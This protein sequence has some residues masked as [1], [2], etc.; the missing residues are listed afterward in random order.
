[1]GHQYHGRI[2]LK[3]KEK[4]TAKARPI[5]VTRDWAVDA[6]NPKSKVLALGNLRRP[7]DRPQDYAT[8]P[9]IHEDPVLSGRARRIQKSTATVPRQLYR[10]ESGLF[11]NVHRTA[12]TA[13]PAGGEFKTRP[14]L[15]G[16]TLDWLAASNG[17]RKLSLPL[18]GLFPS[19]SRAPLFRA[20]ANVCSATV[21]TCTFP[22]PFG[23]RSC[24]THGV[25]RGEKE[26]TPRI[27]C[28]AM[29]C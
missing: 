29:G 24:A 15:R 17:C 22:L 26:L 10:L 13:L 20:C 5:P 3:E 25:R 21:A 12:C 9:I 14:K 7:A 1:M 2:T 19:Q 27:P 23:G 11:R 6:E 28:R 18:Q 8:S 4:V 16:A